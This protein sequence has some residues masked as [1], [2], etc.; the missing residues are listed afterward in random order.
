M[1]RIL[2]FR[3]LK[4]ILGLKDN[5]SIKKFC[6]LNGIEIFCMEGSN[7]KYVSAMQF[8]LALGKLKSKRGITVEKIES[9]MRI[10]SNHLSEKANLLKDKL[11]QEEEYIPQT[12]S[13]IRFLNDL[14]QILRTV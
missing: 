13:E 12:E 5:R 4:R 3:Q 7:Q 1:E 14:T 10:S 9:A 8:Y 6:W 11:N 2:S